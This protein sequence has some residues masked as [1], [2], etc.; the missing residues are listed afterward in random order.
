MG[1]SAAEATTI[2]VTDHWESSQV[3]EQPKYP[4]GGAECFLYFKTL[5]SSNVEK[6][7]SS[8]MVYLY[9]EGSG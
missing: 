6:I 5:S 9:I 7:P 1:F 8:I 3:D 2:C 4:L